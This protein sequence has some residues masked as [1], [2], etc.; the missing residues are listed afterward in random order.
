M[1]EIS[2]LHD[3]LRKW[4]TDL[5]F[6]S[7]S[8]MELRKKHQQ[9]VKVISDLEKSPV[10]PLQWGESQTAADETAHQLDLLETAGEMRSLDELRDHLHLIKHLEAKLEELGTNCL[11]AQDQYLELLRIW[12]SME[13]QQGS[14]WVRN[15]KQIMGQTKLFDAANWKSID[16]IEDFLGKVAELSRLQSKLLPKDPAKAVPEKELSGL[17][18][19][20]KE[21]YGFHLDL[22]PR[23]EKI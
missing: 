22:R 16:D 19:E 9:I 2:G 12:S 18:K 8:L 17:V 1:P 21:L 7:N 15:S 5:E 20:S 23:L 14:E 3:K 11:E 6:I 13:V 10:S 4:K